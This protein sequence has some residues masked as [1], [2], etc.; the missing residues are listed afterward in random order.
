MRTFSEIKS[1]SA[2]SQVIEPLCFKKSFLRRAVVSCSSQAA[3]VSHGEV[4]DI[5]LLSFV[6]VEISIQAD[7]LARASP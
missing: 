2:D 1:V 5:T 4:K 7:D 3:Q 6:F